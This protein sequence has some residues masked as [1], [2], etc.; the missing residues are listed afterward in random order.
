MNELQ[1]LLAEME[2]SEPDLFARI[3]DT[4][5]FAKLFDRLCNMAASTAR[6]VIAERERCIKAAEQGRV[7]CLSGFANTDLRDLRA[8]IIR[9]IKGEQQ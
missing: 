8:D 3:I 7:P 4:P 9:R 1:A 6:E 2:R 5:G